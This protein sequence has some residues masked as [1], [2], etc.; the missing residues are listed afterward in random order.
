M[1]RLAK[2]PNDYSGVRIDNNDLDNLD[3]CVDYINSNEINKIHLNLKKELSTGFIDSLQIS[4][5]VWR[6]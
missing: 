5:N 2:Y 6:K 4:N 1:I 3:K